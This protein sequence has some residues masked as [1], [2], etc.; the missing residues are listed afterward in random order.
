MKREK[1]R[2]AKFRR[3]YREAMWEYHYD[4]EAI[5]MFPHG[6]MKMARDPRV[7]VC[8]DPIEV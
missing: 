1:R 7:V 3:L 5:V 4:P 8:P 6:T 2:Q